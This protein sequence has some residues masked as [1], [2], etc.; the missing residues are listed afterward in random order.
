MLRSL[1]N[2]LVSQT[3]DQEFEFEKKGCKIT[4]SE[5]NF[6][7]IRVLQSTVDWKHYHLYT[8]II[9]HKA[10]KYV[11]KLFT[12]SVV[13]LGLNDP[14]SPFNGRIKYKI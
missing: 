14:I 1:C 8:I 3:P 9:C 10:F 13:K 6:V 2:L 7:V 11:P 5:T 12:M 4:L